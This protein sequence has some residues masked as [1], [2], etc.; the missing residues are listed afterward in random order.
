MGFNSG[1]KGLIFGK[2]ESRMPVAV[3]GILCVPPEPLLGK[4]SSEIKWQIS[5]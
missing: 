3:A 1:F 5:P 2:T 4:I